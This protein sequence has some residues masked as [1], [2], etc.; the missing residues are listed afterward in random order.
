MITVDLKPARRR[1]SGRRQ[2]RVHVTAANGENLSPQDSYANV[3]DA[4]EVP[5]DEIPP[6][7]LNFGQSPCAIEDPPAV[8]EVRTFIVRARCTA[9]HGPIE[10]KDGEMRYTRTLSPQLVWE[11][12]KPK[13][14]DPEEDQ[15]GLFDHNGDDDADGDGVQ[16]VGE[17]IDDMTGAS[18]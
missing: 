12:G 3:V 13:P 15:P 6:A 7:Y 4:I 10:R 14:P 1:F 9:E 8:G 5:S 17:V 18:E 11:Q 2:W 16:S